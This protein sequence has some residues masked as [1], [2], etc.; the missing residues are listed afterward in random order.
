[1]MQVIVQKKML[2]KNVVVYEFRVFL[3][4]YHNGKNKDRK[5]LST[6]FF[7]SSLV[8]KM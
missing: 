6:S 1:M 5:F 7:S 2:K 4:W 3:K 8:F